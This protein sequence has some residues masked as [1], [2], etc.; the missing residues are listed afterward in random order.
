MNKKEHFRIS[1][2]KVQIGNFENFG[3]G[4]LLWAAHVLKVSNI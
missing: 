4:V 3:K 2:Q 1:V